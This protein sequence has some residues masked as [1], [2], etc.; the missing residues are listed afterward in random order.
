MKG[1]EANFAWE[2]SPTNALGH[3]EESRR[4]APRNDSPHYWAWARGWGGEG[5]WWAKVR[6]SESM[7]E[8]T[9]DRALPVWEY[10]FLSHFKRI[11]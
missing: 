1:P 6:D 9:R 2:R 7:V 3:L 8:V 4:D 5:I 11:L 10:L